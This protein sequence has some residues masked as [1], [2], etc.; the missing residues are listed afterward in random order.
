MKITRVYSDDYGESHFEDLKIDLNAAGEIGRL[1]DIIPA[2]GIIFR[3]NKSDH[4]Y[5]WHNE[6][7]K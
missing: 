4:I 1:S 5:D 7:Q 3:E 6:P 2:N